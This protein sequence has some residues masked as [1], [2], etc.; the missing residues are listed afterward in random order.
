M[1]RWVSREKTSRTR[2]VVR[3]AAEAPRVVLIGAEVDLGEFLDPLVAEE[4]VV[5]RA[6][7]A[8]VEEQA[9][10]VLRVVEARL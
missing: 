3:V 2:C 6:V 5:Q 1:S 10:R 8:A 9:E 4:R 7:V